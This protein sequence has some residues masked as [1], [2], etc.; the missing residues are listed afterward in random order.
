MIQEG[1]EDYPDNM[2]RKQDQSEEKINPPVA[3]FF[4]GNI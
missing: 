1:G 2:S 4:L 3:G